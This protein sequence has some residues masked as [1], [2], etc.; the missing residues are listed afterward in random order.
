[1]DL[2]IPLCFVLSLVQTLLFLNHN[3]ELIAFQACGLSKRQILKPI[4]Q[5]SWWLT[6]ALFLNTQVLIPKTQGKVAHIQ[7]ERRLKDKEDSTSAFYHQ[8]LND[9]SFLFYSQYLE[10]EE[11]FQ[12]VYWIKDPNTIWHF[13]FLEFEEGVMCGY[14]ADLFENRQNEGLQLTQRVDK[15][16]LHDLQVLFHEQKREQPSFEFLSFTQMLIKQM[17]DFEK[18]SVIYNQIQSRFWHK[19]LLP[20]FSPLLFFL[21]ATSC[22]KYSRQKKTHL[23]MGLAIFTFVTLFTLFNALSILSEHHIIPASVASI[24]PFM[25]FGIPSIYLYAK[26]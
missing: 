2:L 3:F 12:D 9:D 24:G 26:S 22:M 13:E 5:T 6:I 21:F 1:M 18:K 10:I 20:F 14:L 7:K 8:K 17:K 19:L 16:S 11:R 23:V 15:L 25:L 4:L